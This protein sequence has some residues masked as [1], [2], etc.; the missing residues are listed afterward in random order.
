[1]LPKAE[2]T[3]RCISSAKLDLEGELRLEY[4]SMHNAAHHTWCMHACVCVCVCGV[5][6]CVLLCIRALHRHS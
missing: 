5:C 1:M 2:S 6:V 4:V 3:M